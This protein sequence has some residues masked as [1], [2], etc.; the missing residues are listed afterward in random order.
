[1]RMAAAGR[2][3]RNET[4]DRDK[5]KVKVKVKLKLKRLHF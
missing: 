3:G 1:M 2:N 4:C 5:V